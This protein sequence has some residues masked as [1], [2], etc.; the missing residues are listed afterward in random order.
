MIGMVALAG[1]GVAPILALAVVAVAVVLSPGRS[2]PT[3]RFP[4]S[5][6]GSWR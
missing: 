5:T 1:L 3:R 4:S 6:G 2:T